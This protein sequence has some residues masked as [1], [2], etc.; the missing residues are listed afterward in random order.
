[1]VIG[2]V[3]IKP[4]Q[5]KVISI[6]GEIGRLRAVLVRPVS[7]E[8]TGLVVRRHALPRH[9][10]LIPVAAIVNADQ[11]QVEVLLT[12]RE[13]DTLPE[14]RH[15]TSGQPV[16]LRTTVK[17]PYEPRVLHARGEFVEYSP[18]GLPHGRPVHEG[19][20]A[21]CKDGEA[22]VLDLILM[23]GSTLRV[24]NL[25]VRGGHWL[26]R[27]TLLPIEWVRD[28]TRNT[29][30]LNL[31][32]EEFFLLPA[33]RT[34]E[35]ILE[36]V[37]KVLW[38]SSEL[39]LGDL[40]SVTVQAKEGLVL[41]DGYTRSDAARVQIAALAKQVPGVLG[42]VDHVQPFSVLTMQNPRQVER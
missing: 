26:R 38:N 1:V 37:L 31:T 19:H 13:V 12:F 27:D 4:G 16:A 29:V 15:N 33:Y 41:L 21:L 11:T 40:V 35:D 9:D 20:R 18:P 2:R 30:L 8:S 3:V 17:P 14:F 36:D 25:V 6:D 10:V 24:T 23:E 42:V 7:G 5:T 32:R 22:G 39:E 34:D 28:I